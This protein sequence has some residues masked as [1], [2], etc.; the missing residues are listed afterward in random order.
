L[1]ACLWTPHHNMQSKGQSGLSSEK[2][3]RLHLPHLETPPKS[4]GNAK[5]KKV[6]HKWR[7][8]W[9][10]AEEPPARS[11][12]GSHRIFAS[13]SRAWMASSPLSFSL[14]ATSKCPRAFSF[15]PLTT[16]PQPSGSGGAEAKAAVCRRRFEDKLL[17]IAGTFPPECPGAENSEH[18]GG[19]DTGFGHGPWAI[20]T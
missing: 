2:P 8:P 4:P 11:L 10:A 3:K 17:G 13:P 9:T 18:Q 20:G 7:F 5:V 14:K 15:W 16:T 6:A 1:R 19:H 12:P